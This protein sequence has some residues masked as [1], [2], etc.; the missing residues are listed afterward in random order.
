M[1]AFRPDMLLRKGTSAAYVKC[2]LSA[3]CDGNASNIPHSTWRL[4]CSSLLGL[5]CLMVRDSNRLPK[6]DI[7]LSLQ[8]VDFGITVIL[9]PQPAS[10]CTG[11][12]PETRRWCEVLC[13][14]ADAR[15]GGRAFG[16][17]LH[18]QPSYH[19]S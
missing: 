7:Q 5:S 12:V 18:V 17:Y 6:Q 2:S 4:H 13:E 1:R 10:E 14:D 11:Q 9:S 8:V 3:R 16:S 15:G 19:V